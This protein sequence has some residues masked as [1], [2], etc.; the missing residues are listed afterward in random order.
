MKPV[1]SLISALGLFPALAASASTS[2][3]GSASATVSDFVATTS[4]GP[5]QGVY[6]SN[7]DGV[8]AFK[9][10]PFAASTAGENR[11]K[12]PQDPESWKDVLVADS[13]G[14][15]C[16]QS[17]GGSEDCL[18]VNVWTPANSSDAALPVFVWVYGGRFTS[19]GTSQSLYD[20]AGLAAKD[21]VVVT[22]N[23]RLGVFG[24][25]A[26]PELKE[27]S[28]EGSTG[29]YGHLDQVKALQW[30]QDN[31]AAFGGD[32]TKV[33]IAG[34]SAG[35]SSIYHLVNSPLTKGMIRGAIAESGIRYTHDPLI[36]GLATSYRTNY[37]HAME[38][39]SEYIAPLNTT[40]LDELRALDAAD[41][42]Y[43]NDEVDPDWTG[44][45]NGP[46]F[47]RTVIDGYFMTETYSE[48]LASGPANDVPMITGN[49]K[50]ESGAAT[51]TN[52]TVAEF[53][54]NA[55]TKF[56]DMAS[57]FLTLYPATTTEEASN[58]TNNAA[59]DISRVGTWLFSNAWANSSSSS[60]YQYY[61]THAPPGQSSGAYHMSEI[62]YVFNNLYGTDS[63]WTDEDYEIADMMS[64]YWANFVKY[65]DPN[66]DGLAEWPASS[67]S[68]T[69][70]MHLDSDAGVI[71]L[72]DNSA[73]LDFITRWLATEPEW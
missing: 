38:Q 68:S 13:F 67:A 8:I 11:W 55:E 46:P 72:V 12:A 5:V 26:L 48:S 34:Q 23:Y 50:D 19:G 17:S 28:E 9:G 24:F 2:A 41:L 49:N 22:L 33:T 59:R 6:D 73:K 70:T 14:D 29:N 51:T 62:N 47:F 1:S 58:Q 57:E 43:E 64:S 4:Y 54:E 44:T 40:T 10:I 36:G 21:V 32:P 31:I 37:T 16:L 52:V 71:D 45:D 27:E 42:I 53:T 61:W 18:T 65:L 3:S 56:G 35:A 15:A 25:L 69:T 63:P 60:F 7:V 20:G 39:G 66:G 30:V